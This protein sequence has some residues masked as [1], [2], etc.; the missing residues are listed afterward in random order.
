MFSCQK[1][2]C[3]R[4]VVW[5]GILTDGRFLVARC[6]LTPQILRSRFFIGLGKGTPLAC[7][8]PWHCGC[9]AN[10]LRIFL[11]FGSGIDVGLCESHCHYV[12]S[13]SE[14]LSLKRIR[15]VSSGCCRETRFCKTHL[16]LRF[17]RAIHFSRLWLMDLFFATLNYAG[18]LRSG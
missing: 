10:F 13:K 14:V 4:E 6:G 7:F 12:Q 8:M 2:V 3:W 18:I 5:F 9:A 11:F 16:V 17:V 15:L 1:L